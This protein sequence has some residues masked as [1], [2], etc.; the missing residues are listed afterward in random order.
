[1]N[2]KLRITTLQTKLKWEDIPGNIR[3]FNKLLTGTK[4]GSTDLIVLPEM[5]NTGFSMRPEVFAE[6]PEGATMQWMAAA[7]KDLKSVITGSL[8]IR[9]GKKYFNRLIW[10]RPDGNYDFYDKR[11]L[12]RM[13]NEGN[14]FSSGKKKLIV[15]LKGWKICPLVC[16]DLRF[17][18][19]SRNR[20]TGR[21]NNL[22]AEF[23]VLVYVANWP[24]A[25]I[26][27]WQ[28][29]L[30]AR[31]LENQC[32]VVGVNR[33]GKDGNGMDHAG[34]SVVLDPLGQPL[35]SAGK[36]SSVQTVT[37]DYAQLKS[38]R[39]KFPVLMDGDGFEIKL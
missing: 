3:L 36:K 23:D 22:S 15:E 4:P 17:P 20:L 18:V 21:K 37:L 33:I 1:M 27:T 16:Y 11:H 30:I 31:S 25:R 2:G 12:F 32:F 8:M 5:F 26:Y 24:S 6:K 13:G 29:L 39:E 7:A 9:D 35:F 19:W 34:S 14:V 28:Q 10:M 38:L